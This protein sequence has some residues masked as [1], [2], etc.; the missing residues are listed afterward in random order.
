VTSLFSNLIVSSPVF[1]Q[2]WEASLISP[3]S[4]VTRMY[5]GLSALPV[6]MTAVV[7]AGLEVLS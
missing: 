1:A 3:P 6:T 4:S 2:R 5:T 7:A